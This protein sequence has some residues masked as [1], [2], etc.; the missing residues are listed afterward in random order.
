V[1]KRNIIKFVRDEEEQFAETTGVM[2]LALMP[3]EAY[4]TQKD[5][6]GMSGQ[7]VV[8]TPLKLISELEVGFAHFEKDFD[9]PAF[10]VEFDDLFFGERG[11]RRYNS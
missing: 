1:S 5:N 9:I 7:H 11:I 10:T 6:S 2:R 8:G 4:I 3:G